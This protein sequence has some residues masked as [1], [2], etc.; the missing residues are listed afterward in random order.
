MKLDFVEFNSSGLV[1]NLRNAIYD[2]NKYDFS[3]QNI[4]IKD[5][6]LWNVDIL[7][8]AENNKLEMLDNIEKMPWSIN[9]ERDL[10]GKKMVSAHSISNYIFDKKLLIHIVVQPST[11]GKCFPI[12]YLLNMKFIVSY[13]SYF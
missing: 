8:N 5:L 1:M 7:F 10:G 2:R 4:D 9:V 11:T 6:T 13:I 12:V 3:S